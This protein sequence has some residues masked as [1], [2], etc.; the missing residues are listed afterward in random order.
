LHYEQIWFR[1]DQEPL[2]KPKHTIQEKK[3]MIT[4]AWNPL[5][6]QMLDALQKGRTFDGKYYHDNRLTALVH[7]RPEAG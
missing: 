1:P 5:G 3:I 4:I 7:L 2:E 6:F